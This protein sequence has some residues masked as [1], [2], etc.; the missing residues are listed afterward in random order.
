[1]VQ[2]ACITLVVGVESTGTNLGTT[3][4]LLSEECTVKPMEKNVV[5]L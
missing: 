2:R 4:N 3:S 1:M 5:R